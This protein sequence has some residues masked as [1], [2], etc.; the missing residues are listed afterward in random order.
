MTEARFVMVDVKGGKWPTENIALEPSDTH[1]ML[2]ELK[3][4]NLLI[5]KT[6][7]TLRTE[8]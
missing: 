5:S 1:K 4:Q 3:N 8:S 2:C 6:V 7:S